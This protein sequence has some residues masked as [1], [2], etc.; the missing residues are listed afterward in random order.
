MG[1]IQEKGKSTPRLWELVRTGTPGEP[2]DGAGMEERYSEALG[3]GTDK[4]ENSS[5]RIGI[6]KGQAVQGAGI[7]MRPWNASQYIYRGKK[8]K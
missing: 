2:R 3:A 1:Q 6:R 7:W 4:R 8:K 5:Q